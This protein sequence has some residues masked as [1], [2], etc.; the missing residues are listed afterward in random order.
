MLE[1]DQGAFHP[2]DAVTGR[3]FAM[4]GKHIEAK[5]LYIVVRDHVILMYLY[6]VYKRDCFWLS[7]Q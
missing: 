5:D 1:L 2:G 7:C 4:A 3:V 6:I